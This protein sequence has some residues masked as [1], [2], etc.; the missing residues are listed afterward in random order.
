MKQRLLTPGPTP[1]PEE[2]L[3]EL[4]K[5][6]IYHRTP[7][8][9][10]ILADVLEDLKYVFCTKNI[11]APLTASGSGGM[12]AAIANCLPPGSKAICLIAGR[13][14]ERWRSLCKAFGVEVVSIT[15]P[16]GQAV[17]PEQLSEALAKH[18]D[19]A[20]VTATL[21]E[22]STG[23]RGDIEAFGKIT[24]K[25]PALLL[26]DSISGLGV[27][28]C[29]TDDW[30]IDINV[31]GSQKAL[32]LPPGLAFVS[33]SDK[34]WAKIDQNTATKVFY[35]DLKK[36]RDNL[37]TSD[38]PFTIA[39][40][41]VKALRVSLK[42]LRAEGIEN[43]WKRHARMAAAA[44]AG[45]QA[46]GLELF[47]SQPVDGLTVAKVPDGID[48]VAL[49]LKL[50]KQYGLK[51][52]GGQDTLKGK[53]VRLGHMGYIDQFD[54]LA[55]ISGLELVLLEMRHALE[56]GAGVAAAQQVLAQSVA[57]PQA[58]GV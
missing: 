33:I 10:A 58:A 51:L 32:M 50:E 24:A 45:V 34:A 28:E 25:T 47:A 11:I 43:V 14:G 39:H 53:I 52:A 55:A 48:G 8:F 16:Y 19:A 46:M 15:V 22:T 21:S 3:L 57:A 42:M 31:T 37:K 41:L 9:R 5:P 26:V 27:M 7:Q 54:V 1:V 30:R 35:F 38:T 18:P 44:R 29:R 13:F 56:P 49:L 6:V 2:T 40:T 20:A 4:A 12:E 36:Y 23:V 17:A